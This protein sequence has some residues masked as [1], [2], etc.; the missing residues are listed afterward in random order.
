VAEKIP[1][2]E[3]DE[4]SEQIREQNERLGKEGRVFVRYSGTE[5]KIRLLVEAREEALALNAFGATERILR[6][7]LKFL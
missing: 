5:P 3:F 6:K 1:L 7:E 2:E 4:V